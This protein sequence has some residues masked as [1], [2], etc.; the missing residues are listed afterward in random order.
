MEITSYTVEEIKDPTGIIEGK[1]YEFLL[2]IEV[3]ED[4]ELFRENGLELRVI[5]SSSESSDRIVQHFFIDK[6][7]QEVLEFAMDEDEEAEVL[8]FCINHTDVE[9]EGLLK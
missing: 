4:D 5:L 7:T 8:E 9:D 2:D 1:R 3:E 6:R